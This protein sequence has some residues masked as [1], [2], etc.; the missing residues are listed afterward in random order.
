M[1]FAAIVAKAETKDFND[2]SETHAAGTDGCFDCA[3]SRHMP[4]S[5]LR[6]RSGRP[7]PSMRPQL[8]ITVARLDV[9]STRL[10]HNSLTNPLRFERRCDVRRRQMVPADT[11]FNS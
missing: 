5:R 11:D 2:A 7:R 10:P 8:S 3:W 6:E 9:Q 4:S 1:A